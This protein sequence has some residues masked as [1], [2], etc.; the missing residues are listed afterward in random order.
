ME[1]ERFLHFV[2]AARR[3]FALDNDDALR[4]I[5][6]HV[7]CLRVVPFHLRALYAPLVPPYA[8]VSAPSATHAHFVIRLGE[9]VVLEGRGDVEYHHS[10]TESVAVRGWREPTIIPTDAVEVLFHD[11]VHYR[12]CAQ[13]ALCFD[14]WLA[15]GLSVEVTPPLGKKGDG[16]L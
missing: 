12:C 2:L 10:E 14:P 6:E 1:A 16:G 4:L 9:D 13:S 5:H 11:E 7:H 15:S 3:R 8:L